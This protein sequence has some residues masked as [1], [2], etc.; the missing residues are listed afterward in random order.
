MNRL[1]RRLLALAILPLTAAGVLAGDMDTVTGSAVYRERMLL[2]SGAIFEATLAEVSRV[3]APAGVIATQTVYSPRT[4]PIRFSLRYDPAGID[5]RHTY[6]VHARITAGGKLLFVTDRAYPVITRGAERKIEMILKPVADARGEAQP[7]APAQ[8]TALE[9]T[10]WRLLEVAGQPVAASPAGE[11]QAHLRLT[12]QDKR[13][14]GYTGCN[15]MTGGYTLE[16][17]ALRFTQVAATQRFC[18]DSAE[19]ETAFTQA[20]GETTGYRLAAGQLELLARDR[21]VAKLAA[22]LGR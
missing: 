19:V 4:S 22:V 2:P 9:N 16:G 17:D 14:Q 5:P 10:D 20:L 12:A 6:S 11:R 15:S 13:L 3:D 8:G 18:A 1:A 21:V 7:A